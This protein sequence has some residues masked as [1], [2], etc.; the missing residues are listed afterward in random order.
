MKFLPIGGLLLAILV[1]GGCG[2]S[3]KEAQQWAYAA[4]YTLGSLE[5]QTPAKLALTIAAFDATMKEMEFFKGATDTKPSEAVLSYRGRGDITVV[6][7]LKEFPNYTNIKV[8]CGLLGE[9]A[10]GREILSKFYRRI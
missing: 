4:S 2:K 1:C 9:E 10:L 5:T 7:K 8:R 6:V 3:E